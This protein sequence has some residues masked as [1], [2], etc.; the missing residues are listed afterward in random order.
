MSVPGCITGV[1]CSA[2]C[3]GRSLIQDSNASPPQPGMYCM[4]YTACQ[5][6]EERRCRTASTRGQAERENRCG[7]TDHAPTAYPRSHSTPSNQGRGTSCLQAW[8]RES[9]AF[10]TILNREAQT[11]RERDICEARLR[12]KAQEG[13]S[14]QTTDKETCPKKVDVS[15][16]TANGQAAMKERLASTNY[17]G[18]PLKKRALPCKPYRTQT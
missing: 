12:E 2:Q 14:K 8:A 18:R 17:N 7:Q 5:Y 16:D 3:V 13:N 15:I 9:R 1:A 11:S 6:A 10:P 4:E